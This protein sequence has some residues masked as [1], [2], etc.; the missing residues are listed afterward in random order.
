MVAKVDKDKDG[1]V[2]LEEFI[3]LFRE[4]ASDQFDE[5]SIFKQ[6]ASLSEVDVSA[7]SV[8]SLRGQQKIALINAKKQFDEYQ[9][10]SPLQTY[11]EQLMK[12]IMMKSTITYLHVSIT[13]YAELNNTHIVN[14]YYFALMKLI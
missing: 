12:G 10:C 14:I 11:I 9:Y 6:L 3:Q 5:D 2:N 1:A 7:V 13:K 8:S 4:A